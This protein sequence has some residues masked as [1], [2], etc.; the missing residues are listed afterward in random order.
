LTASGTLNAGT[1]TLDRVSKTDHYLTAGGLSDSTTAFVVDKALIEALNMSAGQIIT[2]ADLDSVHAG[3][4]NLTINGAKYITDK[5]DLGYHIAQD[6]ATKDII[7]IARNQESNYVWVGVNENWSDAANWSGDMVPDEESWVQFNGGEQS[8]LLDQ[9]VKTRRLTVSA[10][11][12]DTI[13]GD[14]NLLLSQSL[15]VDGNASLNVGDGSTET[16]V[17]APEVQV[18]GELNVQANAFVDAGHTTIKGGALNVAD[19]GSYFTG[20]V[21]MTEGGSLHTE[22]E[23]SI[24]AEQL[25]GDIDSTVGGNVTIYGNGGR[26]SGGYDGAHISVV[27]DAS[28]TL[29]AGEGLTLHGDGT[30]ALLY[31]GNEAIDGVEADSLHIILNNPEYDNGSTLTLENES[32]LESGTIEFG[33]SAVKRSAY[34]NPAMAPHIVEGDLVLGDDARVVVNQDRDTD[35]GKVMQVGNLGETRNLVLAH[36]GSAATDTRNVLLNGDLYYKYYKNARIV[37]GELTVDLND[38]YYQTVSGA[39]SHNGRAGAGM[40]DDALVELNPQA[41]E[42]TWNGDLAAVMTA[43]DNGAYTAGEADRILAAMSGASAAAMGA[44]WNRD[45]DRQLRA[46]RNRTTSMG[47]GECEVNEEMPYV[48]AWINA[49]GDYSR[50]DSDGTFAG[51]KL[52]SWG[53]T[54]GVDVDCTQ[55]LTLGLAATA[56]YGDFTANSG[57]NAKGDLNRMYVTVFG[58]YNHHAWTHTLIATAG[59]A[60]TKLERTVNY[61]TGAY[62][63]RS[64]SHGAAYGLMYELG[65]TAALTEDASTCLQPVLNLSFRHSDIDGCTEKGGS[66]AAL[67]LGDAKANVFTAALGARLQSAIGTSA[68]NRAS[69]FEGRVMFKLDSGDRAT[70]MDNSFSGVSARRKVKSS[71]LGAFGLEIGAGVVIPIAE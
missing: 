39:T 53:G 5:H 37:D 64:D 9:L 57:D 10:G 70:S 66:D 4:A 27:P 61:G 17:S 63:T 12:H 69:L 47:V 24:A 20:V 31:T 59:V 8:I 23:A 62:G 52:S 28:T 68:Y 29:Y 58:R 55:R 48:N 56:M 33:M 51:Y 19:G 15:E 25:N 22:G 11:T 6:S 1:I 30:V 67:R 42:D 26:Y 13:Y 7:L 60:D 16:M 43:L 38:T 18:T 36:I 2:L 49:E 21:D 46:I 41:Y 3:A 44:A 35:K 65:Y 32:T 34:I 40:L 50:M 71:E 14:Q 54:V 45:V